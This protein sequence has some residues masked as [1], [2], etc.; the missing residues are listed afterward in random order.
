MKLFVSSSLSRRAYSS[1]QK[2]QIRTRSWRKSPT[3][4]SIYRSI[5]HLGDPNVSV[6]PALDEWVRKGNSANKWDLQRVIT[7]LMTFK[8]FRHALEVSLWMS[9]EKRYP[10]SPFDIA[11]RLKLILKNFSIEQTE[12]YFSKIP[13]HVR[14][15]QIYLALL[16]CYTISKYVDKA[17]S[18][19]QKARDL[20][21]A[22]KPIWY[23]LM[24]NLYCRLG[25]REKL[26]ELLAEMELKG[27]C[28]D[29]FT[30]SVCLSA[31]AA[32]SDAEGM[33]R[34]V[35]VMESDPE[36]VVH[37]RTLVTAAQG[38]L[39]IGSTDEAVEVLKKLEKQLKTCSQKYVLLAFILNLYAEAG[40]K[41]ELYRIWM[42][43]KDKKVVNK[44][45]ICMMRSLMKFN[46]I[47]GMEKIFEEWES[48]ASL[49][50][51]RVANFL[52]DAYCTG[53]CVEK[54]EALIDKVVSKGGR[55]LVL[56]WCHLAGGYV[57][58]N[59][60]AE[61][62]RSLR[63]GIAACPSKFMSKKQALITCLE[64][65]QSNECVEEAQELIMSLRTRFISEPSAFNELPG[66]REDQDF[67]EVLVSEDEDVND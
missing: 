16:N 51:F 49:F 18:I 21:Y 65:L 35:R 4:E 31:C 7:E 23:N 41:E 57:K 22:D 45:Y 2:T 15:Y 20:G 27:I 54:A 3:F 43:S 8:R 59:Q 13:E 11:V 26:H 6:V 38:Y 39:R 61:A 42:A 63:K 10:I 24:M 17:E 64:Y 9:N 55:P 67:E 30:Y 1:L 53:G 32:A 47:N 50:D 25:N 29:E 36:V 60:I 46:D 37:W 12:S 40:K 62:M 66:V 28:Y 56:T 34:V 33:E 52:I 58:K 14:T 48:G 19:L 44:V 5:A